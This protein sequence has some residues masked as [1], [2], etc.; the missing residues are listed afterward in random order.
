[1]HNLLR[2]TFGV[3]PS[4]A[5]VLNA[6]TPLARVLASV[7][8][9]QEAASASAGASDKGG[10]PAAPARPTFAAIH[11]SDDADSARVEDLDLARFG[12]LPPGSLLPPTSHAQHVLLTGANGF[13]GRFLLLE[14]LRALQEVDGTMRDKHVTVLVRAASDEAARQRLRQSFGSLAPQLAAYEKHVTVLAGELMQ[15]QFGLPSD[16]YARLSRS[17]DSV[18]HNG[19]LVNHSFRYAHLFEP[20]VLGTVEV[21]RFCLTDRAKTLTFTSSVA[22][23]EGIGRAT[24][25]SD[26]ASKLW[27]VRPLTDE[28]AA[29]YASSKWASEVQLE[30]LAR[31]P[32][33]LPVNI[34]RCSMLLPPC[35]AH[36]SAQVN[37]NDYLTRLLA[38]VV[39]TGLRPASLYAGGPSA[40]K[41]AHFDGL[42][43]DVAAAG[44]VALVLHRREPSQLTRVH[45]VNSHVDDGVS[46]DTF[47]DWTANAKGGGYALRIVEPYA[48][49]LSQYSAALDRLPSGVKE[50]TNASIL[51]QWRQPQTVPDPIQSR[52]DS[53]QFNVLLATH[54][55]FPQGVQS[56]D[57]SY[58]THALQQMAAIDILPT[59]DKESSSSSSSSNVGGSQSSPA[60]PQEQVSQL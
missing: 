8:A 11:G 19:A 23:L 46:L 47:L 2:D 36:V 25:E 6:S 1:L 59:P 50:K 39:W 54:T 3:A 22:V 18:L 33:G 4:V 31:A 41:H 37:T 42:P 12:L 27:P 57:E 24:D 40:A 43:V 29:G 56:L 51:F 16:V 32:Y 7:K 53:R 34:V 58:W 17:V 5:A 52:I 28:Y 21:I 60:P 15:P 55:R 49:W 38:G 13:F 20:N 48:V 30:Q 45:C 9:M 35:E 14:L 26:A 44:I 10:A